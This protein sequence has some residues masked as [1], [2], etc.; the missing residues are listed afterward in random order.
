MALYAQN[1]CIPNTC[2]GQFQFLSIEI[3]IIATIT[4]P[5]VK[6]ILSIPITLQNVKMYD[7]TVQFFITLG[8]NISGLDISVISPD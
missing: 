3:F 1:I 5:H 4:N 2:L 8:V 6:I 7:L